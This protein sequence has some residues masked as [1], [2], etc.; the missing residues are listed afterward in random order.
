MTLRSELPVYS[1]SRHA[2]AFRAKSLSYRRHFQALVVK[3]DDPLLHVVAVHHRAH[4]RLSVFKLSP[5]IASPAIVH[6]HR[7]YRSPFLSARYAEIETVRNGNFKTQILN[8]NRTETVNFR[9][10][11]PLHDVKTQTERRRN[12]TKRSV[13]QKRCVK[14][15]SQYDAEPRVAARRGALQRVGWFTIFAH[16]R[17]CDVQP[18]HPSHVYSVQSTKFTINREREL[19]IVL[20]LALY[21]RQ[22]RRRKCGR[23]MWIRGIFTRCQQQGEYHQLLH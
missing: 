13:G 21:L 5:S 16:T 4:K 11:F 18:P 3:E 19:E 6:A 9:T 10:A 15:S 22:R 12:G 17:V 1:H 7:H 2:D 14:P 23:S 20:V 8:L